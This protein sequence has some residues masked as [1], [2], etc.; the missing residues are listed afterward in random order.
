MAW[1]TNALGVDISSAQKGLEWDVIAPFIDFAMIRAGGTDKSNATVAYDSQFAINIQ[2][3][4]D[5]NVPVGVY[6]VPDPEL[7][8]V[9]QVPLGGYK[10]GAR[11]KDPEYSFLQKVLQNKT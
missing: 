5:N 7:N 2:G 1:K 3:A 4:Y 10:S 8:G 9:L 11:A 6:F